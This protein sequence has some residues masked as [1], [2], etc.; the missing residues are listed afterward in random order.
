MKAT[1]TL[2][3]AV[4]I[5]PDGPT[6]PDYF[7]TF[8]P[9]G[10]ANFHLG[11]LLLDDP[12]AMSYSLPINDA[13]VRHL[14]PHHVTITDDNGAV[15]F[16]ADIA[17]H[18]WNSEWN[19]LPVNSMTIKRQP[20]DLVAANFIFPF[21]DTG[22]AINALPSDTYKGPGDIAGLVAY[23]PTTGERPEIGWVTD[24][25]A[26]FM[27]GGSEGPMLADAQGGNTFPV[28]FR[29]ER[30]GKPI[31]LTKYPTANCAD[32]PNLQGIP[33]LDKGPK[34]SDGYP[35]YGGGLTPQEAHRPSIAYVACLATMN[36]VYLRELQ[37][38]ANFALVSN[39]YLSSQLGL[40]TI[41]GERRAIAWGL[42]DLF[43]AHATTKDF[44][45]RGALP[46]DCMP[47]SYFKTLLDQSLAY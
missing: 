34:A 17:A 12:A 41:T 30:T 32:Q 38:N 6:M 4:Y 29:D 31:D 46:D 26:E 16:D 24:A 43:M 27:L 1:I 13:R 42:R 3:G 25:E 8:R 47:S 33:Y 21:G 19:Y 35:T 44:E 23:E 10:S 9:D 15:G 37:Y 7:V 40:A 18:Y 36:P 28:F 11:T 20:D 14:G 2:A 39:A 22:N 45:A 5:Y